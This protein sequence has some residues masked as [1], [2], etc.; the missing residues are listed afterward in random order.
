MSY[1][2]TI[3]P[4]TIQYQSYTVNGLFSCF[5]FMLVCVVVVLVISV[6]LVSNFCSYFFCFLARDV[7]YTSRAYATM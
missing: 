5:S 1:H 2:C 3:T 6:S 4:R 7:I